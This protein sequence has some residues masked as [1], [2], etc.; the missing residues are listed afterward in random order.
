MAS[1][2]LLEH[3]AEWKTASDAPT[4]STDAFDYTCVDAKTADGLRRGATCV[5]RLSALRS[6]HLLAIGEQLLLDKT[7]LGHGRFSAWL[8]AEF[9][10]TERSA[11]RFIRARE[12]FGAK[13]DAVSVLPPTALYQLSAKST[14]DMVRKPS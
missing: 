5:H 1:E 7:L 8:K 9:G 11:Q 3:D 14:P 4:P 12:T 10:W 6:A 2:H 13:N